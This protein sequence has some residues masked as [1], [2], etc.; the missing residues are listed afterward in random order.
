MRTPS[1]T[2][3]LEARKN[4]NPHSWMP[5]IFMDS[6]DKSAFYI[7]TMFSRNI[8]LWLDSAYSTSLNIYLSLHYYIHVTLVKFT[9]YTRVIKTMQLKNIKRSLKNNKM[10]IY[11]NKSTVRIWLRSPAHLESLHTMLV[12]SAHQNRV[13]AA[14]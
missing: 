1:I 12:R 2:A 14:Q 3:Y 7:Y 11:S 9:S 10:F 5:T 6:V 8:L 13:C 4:L